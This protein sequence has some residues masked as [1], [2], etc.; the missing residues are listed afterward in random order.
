[1]VNKNDSRSISGHGLPHYLLDRAGNESGIDSDGISRSFSTTDSSETTA[2][3]TDVSIIS[4]SFDTS[5]LNVSSV[6]NTP[7]RLS[8]VEQNSFQ[9]ESRTLMNSDPVPTDNHDHILRS[10]KLLLHN[11]GKCCLWGNSRVTMCG[12]SS[13]NYSGWS[14]TCVTFSALKDIDIRSYLKTNRIRSLYIFIDD[15]MSF[16][17]KHRSSY[18]IDWYDSKS[19]CHHL[20]HNSKHRPSAR[21]CRRANI[22]TCSKI[23][24]FPVGG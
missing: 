12:N 14:C 9:Y 4:K 18:G 3:D 23:E 15:S 17:P 2:K 10:V 6:Y 19:T 21:D 5:S 11:Y 7:D 24:G 13:P 20:G 16:C 1:M 22:T 8:F